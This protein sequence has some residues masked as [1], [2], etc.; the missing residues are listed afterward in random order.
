MIQFL[1][2]KKG[3]F[4]FRKDII[5]PQTITIPH[6]EL[7]PDILQRLPGWYRSQSDLRELP[8]RNSPTPY[9]T[10][11]S[12][13]M[14]QQTR[15]SA[16][17]PYYER[18]LA[19]LP[20]IAALAACDDEALMK[21]WQGLGY[22][23]RARNLKKAAIA[24][25]QEY[26]GKL[27][28]DFKSLLALPGI[29][30]YTASAIGS[31][32]Y[33]KPWPAVDGNV[34]RV[35]SRALASPA[36][37]ALPATKNSLEQTLAPHYPQGQ[38]AGDINQAFMDL[39]ATICLPKGMPHCPQCP[40]EKI[41]LAHAE[42]LEL[43]LPHKSS[44]RKR[45][46]EKRT[47]LLLIQGN[48]IALHKRPA[49][50]L[51]AGLWEFPNLEGQLNKT[52]V[53]KWLDAHDLTAQNLQQLPTAKHVF[54]HIEWQLS[55]WRIELAPVS[56]LALREN[57]LPFVWVTQQELAEKFSLPSAFHYYLSEIC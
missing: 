38:D 43:E 9:H 14:L 44:P 19:S 31:I 53:K 34:L 24:I 40:L 37:I 12:E 30:R 32:A 47:V 23:S 50:G 36:D 8:W 4:S 7:I 51:L 22:Y 56:G 18:F 15:A 57:A 55:G 3:Y 16:V 17:I 5:L 42:G 2:Y 49:A 10:W 41:C 39:G 27:P 46:H 48:T 54:S 52:A 21:L 33:G 13:I 29:G 6:A 1:H 26:D 28:Q 11:L 35:L 20:D 25:C 45:R